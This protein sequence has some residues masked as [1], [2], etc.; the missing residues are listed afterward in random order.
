MAVIE[1]NKD[2]SRRELLIFG[3]L[4]L[5]FAALVGGMA[6]WKFRAR[7]LGVDIWLAGGA[8]SALYFL[9]PP[10]R[11]PLYVGWMY[12][13]FPVGFVVSHVILAVIYYLVISPIGVVM[14]LLGRDPME[15]TFD[16]KAKSYWVA[17]DPHKDPARYF[18]QF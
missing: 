1:I 14:R 13:A 10:I 7:N 6:Y 3:L 8:I 15:R 16:S 12:A 2:P 18:R 17:H 5:A 9:I 11:R 4:L